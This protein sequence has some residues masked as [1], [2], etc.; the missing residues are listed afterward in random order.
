MRSNNF[1]M[2]LRS[3]T[4]T[5]GGGDG[6]GVKETPAQKLARLEKEN[7]GMRDQIERRAEQDRKTADEEKII[8]E[9][10]RLGLTRDQAV[11]VIRRQAQHDA[12][13]EKEWAQRR[14]QIIEMLKEHGCISGPVRLKVR[15]EIREING[16][17]TIDEIVKAQQVAAS[18]AAPAKS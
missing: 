14:P 8:Q 7:A 3:A 10:I 11:A 6:A 16:A 17:I 12:L 18:E 2:V 1:S 5:D 15:R 9:K 13:L 4:P